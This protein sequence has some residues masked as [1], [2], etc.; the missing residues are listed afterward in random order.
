MVHIGNDWDEILADEFSKPYY[1]RLR[2]F[3]KSEYSSRSIFP[4]MN[5]IF[6]ALRY[7]S[8]SDTKVCILGQDPYHEPGQAHGLCFSVKEGVQPPPSLLNIYKEI[9]ADVG[10]ENRNDF[11]ELTYWA[12]QGILL[13]NTVLTVRQGA[14][15]S[16]KGMGWEQFTDRVISELNRKSP[17]VVFLLWGR[18][19]RDKA[20]I[21]DNPLHIKLCCAH[22]SPLSA[23]NGFFGC[24]HFSKTNEILVRN[25][26][27][28]IDWSV[29]KV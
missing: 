27:T 8:F 7:T 19:A 1:K 28:P 18:N 12:N 3:L 6:N 24:R 26:L 25:G 23:Y 5:D 29:K 2:A 22:P 9:K 11:G 13:L 4:D 16:H 15:N 21:I 14:A 20:Q 17:P 10:I